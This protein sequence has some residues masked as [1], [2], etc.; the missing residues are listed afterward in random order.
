MLYPPSQAHLLH[1]ADT[2]N[3]DGGMDTRFD[4]LA[5]DF[6]R[7]PRARGATPYVAECGPGDTILVPCMV[8]M[9]VLVGLSQLLGLHLEAWG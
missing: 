3:G 2:G 7:F 6:G 5:P 9:A 8:R 1:A 4:P